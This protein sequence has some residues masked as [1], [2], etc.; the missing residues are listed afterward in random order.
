MCD[1][2]NVVQCVDTVWQPVY[3]V[4]Y[5]WELSDSLYCRECSVWTGW[6]CVCVCVS[7]RVCVLV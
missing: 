1:V 3:S 7:M 6:F 2:Y 5:G 4:M